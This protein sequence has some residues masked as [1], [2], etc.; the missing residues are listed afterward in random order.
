LKS[1]LIHAAYRERGLVLPLKTEADWRRLRANYWGLN[2]LVDTH[3]G[4]ILRTI[5][6]CGLWDDTIIVFTS[7]HG[8][9]MGSHQLVAKCVMFEEATRVPLLIKPAGRFAP[10]RVSHPV[11]QIDLVPTLLDLLGCQVPGHLQA[12]VANIPMTCSLNG[13]ATRRGYWSRTNRR[14]AAS[15]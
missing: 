13:I 9:M 3:A 15:G 7:D 11:S 6:D 5:E 2:S 8:D 1:R 10:R 14:S 12:G 4:T